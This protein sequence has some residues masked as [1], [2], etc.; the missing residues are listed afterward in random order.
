MQRTYSERE[1]LR[2]Y[3]SANDLR[4]ASAEVR[5]LATTS[6]FRVATNDKTRLYKEQVSR[7]ASQRGK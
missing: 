5:P 2:R 7:W 6:S 4:A 3:N 1:L